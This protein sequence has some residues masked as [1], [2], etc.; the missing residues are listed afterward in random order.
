MLSCWLKS[1]KTHEVIWEPLSPTALRGLS[2][3]ALVNFQTIAKLY[4]NFSGVRGV[5]QSIYLLRFVGV[6]LSSGTQETQ[7]LVATGAMDKIFLLEKL[8]L[9]I[10]ILIEV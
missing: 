10:L 1:H 3:Q 9:N 7:R 2:N 4:F 8:K 5:S 6:M